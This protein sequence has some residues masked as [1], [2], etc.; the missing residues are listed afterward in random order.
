MFLTGKPL[1]G[2]CF[3]CAL[4]AL[5]KLDKKVHHSKMKE[6]AGELFPRLKKE[7]KRDRS[8]RNHFFENGLFTKIG[9]GELETCIDT[10]TLKGNNSIEDQ[11]AD[12]WLP[13]RNHAP[14]PSTHTHTRLPLMPDKNSRMDCNAMV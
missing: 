1:Y 4:Y 3:S 12:G 9:S 13:W 11:G 5:M 2:L 8:T 14:G 7:K 6:G 10:R